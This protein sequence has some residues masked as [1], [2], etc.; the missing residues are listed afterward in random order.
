VNRA[1]MQL[2]ITGLVYS[3]FPYSKLTLSVQV[4]NAFT[5]YYYLI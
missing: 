2:K 1:I 5:I 4:G 3:S